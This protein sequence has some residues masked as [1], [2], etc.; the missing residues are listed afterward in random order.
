[1]AIVADIEDDSESHVLNDRKS[2]ILRH[3]VETHVATAQPV[4]SAQLAG[5][6]ELL[7]S[8]ATIRNEM[9]ALEREGY[10]THP[11]TSAGRVPTDK[12]YR[13]VVDHP[14][15]SPG[16]GETE[17]ERVSDF[18]D[19]THG[20]LERL[21]SDTSR[22]LSDLTAYAAVVAP[23]VDMATIRSLQIVDLGPGSALVVAV[24][25]NG[26][27]DKAPLELADSVT[28][29]DLAIATSH[30]T[31]MVVG[32]TVATIAKGLQLPRLGQ[33]VVDSLCDA[34]LAALHQGD[35][36]ADH[37]APSTGA[38]LHVAGAARVAQAFDAVE[39][40]RSVLTALEEQYV[41]VSL[42]RE[43]AGRS[44]SV[45]IGAEHGADDAFQQLVGCSIVAAPY[46]VDG[47]VVGRIG[48]LGPTRMNYPQ[49]MA[50]V[51]AV[52]RRLSERLTDG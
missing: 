37:V 20:E 23:E 32:R 49:A 22:L 6:K 41:V 17:I 1:V 50:A 34:A 12:G 15:S 51:A 3:V 10:L 52:S 30:L 45:S 19:R 7:V 33:P 31:N 2:T 24:L 27:V 14:G 44:A 35:H 8:P 16:L 38:G 13:Y 11:H 40:V 47:R 36:T 42:L 28:A 39:T 18:F 29:H 43:A 48:V 9:S 26:R 25:S 46:L 4:G 21:L 5:A